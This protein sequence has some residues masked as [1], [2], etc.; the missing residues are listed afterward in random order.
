ML[1]VRL[2]GNS[3]A[4]GSNAA[5]YLQMCTY[6][7]EAV[8]PGLNASFKQPRLK[9]EL[10]AESQRTGSALFTKNEHTTE[11]PVTRDVMAKPTL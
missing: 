9:I 2:T 7:T 8:A 10:N 4:V 11:F 3:T 6:V 5:V 1:E